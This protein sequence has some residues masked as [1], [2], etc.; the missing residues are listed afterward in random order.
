MSSKLFQP[1]RVGTVKLDHRIVMAP[2][3]RLRADDEH[4]QLPI[5]V[6]YYSQRASVPGTLIITEAT[7]ISSAHSGFPYA[8]G[9]WTSAQIAGWKL[10]TDAVH[11][12]KC[13]IFA[14]LVAPGRAATPDSQHPLLSSSATR[15]TE[16]DDAVPQEMSHDQIM[17]C[18]GEFKQ[19]ARNAMLAGFD[20]GEIHG[21]NGYLVDQFL[22]DNCNKRR[23][24]WG[25]DVANRARFAL[26]IAA[27][28]IDA[29]GAE[30]VGFRLSP[31]SLFQGMRMADP[32]P[33]FSYLVEQLKLLG[34]AYIHIIEPRVN[35]NFDCETSDSIDFLLAIWGK[36]SPVLVAG[37]YTPENAIPAIDE[38]YKSYNVAVV[39]GRHFLANPDLPYRIKHGLPLNK[40]DRTS[41]YTP[42]LPV[43]YIDYP[44]SSGFINGKA[45]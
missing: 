7:L 37:G 4:V 36:T 8:P 22:Q 13:S 34:L 40:Y 18:I 41:F 6:E 16:E 26:E 2:L 15:M 9:L 27:A 29:V 39:F 14:Q 31:F 12:R 25:G 19:A 5:A 38:K 17:S 24:S 21:A 20:G 33:Q 23:D 44:F 10:I 1:L 35:N 43:G 28:L 30:K 42:G 45:L 32:I 11:A 3:T